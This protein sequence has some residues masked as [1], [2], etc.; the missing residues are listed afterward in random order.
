MAASDNNSIY[1]TGTRDAVHRVGGLCYETKEL[2]ACSVWLAAASPST[3]WQRFGRGEGGGCYSSAR[4]NLVWDMH[5]C[6]LAK[7]Q[8]NT[9]H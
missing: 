4:Q 8:Q 5:G 3:A 7:V 1:K 6:P 2:S 9:S